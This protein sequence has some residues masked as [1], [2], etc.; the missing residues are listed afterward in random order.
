MKRKLLSMLLTVAMVATMLTGCG[1]KEA[2]SGD[3]EVVEDGGAEADGGA[4]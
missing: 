3:A 2:A 1:S 4:L